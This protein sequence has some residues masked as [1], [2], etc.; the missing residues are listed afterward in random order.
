MSQFG[1]QLMA[2][3]AP[4]WAAFRFRPRRACGCRGSCESARPARVAGWPLSAR[5]PRQPHDD[6]RGPGLPLLSRSRELRRPRST[7]R[8][9]TSLEEQ[10]GDGQSEYYYWYYGTLAMFQRQGDDWQAV[11]RGPAAAAA[12]TASGGTA[13]GRQLGPRRCGAA[14]AAASIARPW[15]RCRL[16]VYYRYLPIYGEKAR[17]QHERFTDRPSA[18][19]CRVSENR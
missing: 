14:T 9:L 19:R 16:E 5:R 7:K 2:L 3:E 12:R 11:E 8:P 17:Q 18:F 10:P 13:S 6:G 15:P 4:S 1:W